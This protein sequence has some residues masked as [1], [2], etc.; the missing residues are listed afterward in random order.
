MYAVV[1][2]TVFPKDEMR[3]CARR[4]SGEATLLELDRIQGYS[5]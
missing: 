3:R 5:Y 1:R 4:F 2:T